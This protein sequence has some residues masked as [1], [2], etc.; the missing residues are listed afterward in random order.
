M[1][2][3]ASSPGFL[4]HIVDDG[5]DHEAMTKYIDDLEE[6]GFFA[7]NFCSHLVDINY[8][9][10]QRVVDRS[11]SSLLAGVSPLCA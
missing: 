9:D 11:S 2:S 4:I 6:T 3:P 1:C 5:I 8:I 7:F 10:K